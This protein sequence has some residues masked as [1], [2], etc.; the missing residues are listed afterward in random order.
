MRENEKMIF[1]LLF[2]ATWLAAKIKQGKKREE[3]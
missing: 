3:K 1:F 2:S